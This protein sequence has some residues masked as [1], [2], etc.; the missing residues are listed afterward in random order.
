MQWGFFKASKFMASISSSFSSFLGEE[1][2]VQYVN[3]KA[4]NWGISSVLWWVFV[5]GSSSQENSILFF[6]CFYNFFVII[7]TSSLI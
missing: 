1:F 2:I 3:N 6:I 4:N 5:Y 7:S